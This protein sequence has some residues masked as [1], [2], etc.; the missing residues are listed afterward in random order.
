MLEKP[1]LPDSLILSRV[2][3]EY[4][5][6]VCR[7]TFLPIGADVNTAVY[8]I[9]T[10]DN[11]AYFLKL[12]KGSFEEITVTL[13][14]FLKNQGVPSIITPL[15]A[16]AGRLWGSLDAYKMILYPFVEGQ[17]AYEAA[18]SDRQWLVFGAALKEI[19]NVRLPTTLA[20]QIP[21]ENF[22]PQWREMVK[23]F[24]AQAEKTRFKDLTAVK[25]AGFMNAR[26]SEI[27]LLV[28][29][30]YQ[31][32][33][34]LRDRPTQLVLSHS[35]IHAGNLLL[36]A[37]DA[38]YIVDWD[39]P[40][41]SPKEHDLAMVGG[42]TVWSDARAEALFYQGYGQVVIDPAALA[43]YRCE[44]IILDIAEYCEQLLLSTEGGEDREQSYQYFTGIFLPDHEV[45][46]ALS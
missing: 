20:A 16:R 13:P 10:V 28:S 29:R 6:Q 26:R 19:H 3:D 37:N 38:L 9:D 8:R 23:D 14:M 35:D 21:I 44:R 12:R 24:Q 39:N 25:M 30:A 17:N 1:D 2:Q 46:L 5:L 42:S 15:P 22:S 27:D 18:P 32:G 4:D 7:V 33:R 34:V 31:L 43:Y 41:F 11:T 36:G 45:D 40:I